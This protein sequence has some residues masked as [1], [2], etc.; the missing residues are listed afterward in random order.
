MLAQKGVNGLLTLGLA[1]FQRTKGLIKDIAHWF[2]PDYF[3][4]R[5]FR[6]VKF[7]LKK[8]STRYLEDAVSL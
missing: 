7:H 8:L 2:D 3:N 4:Q 6:I 1:S 5:L